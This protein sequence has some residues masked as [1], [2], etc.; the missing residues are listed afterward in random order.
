MN[1]E[2]KNTII[3]RIEDVLSYLLSRKYDCD[4]KIHFKRM[5]NSYGNGNKTG[6][7]GEKQI[8]DRKT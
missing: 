3:E 5:E 2:Q 1:E 8:L 6:S 4:I 7:I